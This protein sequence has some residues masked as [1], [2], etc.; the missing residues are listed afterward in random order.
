MF[1]SIDRSIEL[2]FFMTRVSRRRVNT[3]IEA[4]IYE[5][6][7]EHLAQLNTT[8][9]I[10]EFLQSLLSKSEQIMLSK[11]LAIALMLAK[12]YTYAS[13]DET[14]KVSKAT[15]TTIQRQLFT[16]AP[17]YTKAIK[18]LK[19]SAQKQV[20]WDKI[21]ELLLKLSPPAHVGSAQFSRKSAL[22]KALHKR[23]IQ[24]QVL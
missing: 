22:G 17:G 1:S 5:V 9:L 11:R 6:F 23:K 13:I 16:G 15:I 14:L 21:E 10:K 20:T 2:L 4:R 24:R 19:K 18:L 8:P 12:G 7:W 3:I